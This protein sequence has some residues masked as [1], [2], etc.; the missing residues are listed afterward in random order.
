NATGVVRTAGIEVEYNSFSD[1]MT[2]ERPLI[3]MNTGILNDTRNAVNTGFPS[4][5]SSVSN[6]S[7]ISEASWRKGTFSNREAK[8][9]NLCLGGLSDPA[10]NFI[11]GPTMFSKTS[12]ND[13][14]Q[15]RDGGPAAVPGPSMDSFNQDFSV[16]ILGKMVY[17]PG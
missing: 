13:I 8:R 7:I 9:Y 1:A 17:K 6:Y 14:I 12:I 16:K 3:W 2:P 11:S 4:V 5:D 10:P 15:N